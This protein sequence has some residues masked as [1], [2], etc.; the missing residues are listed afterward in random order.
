MIVMKRTKI[1]LSLVSITTAYAILQSIKS[2]VQV[3]NIKLSPIGVGTWAWGNRFLWQYTE[4]DDENLKDTY[5]YVVQKGVNWFDT[6]DSY[7]T[8]SLNGR[9]E[10]L[11][12]KF[13]QGSKFQVSFAT[14]L[15]PY[16]WRIGTASMKSACS[17]SI[18]RLRRPVDVLQLHWPP[19]LGWQEENY[20][21]AFSNLVESGDAKQIGVSNYG[22]IGLRRVDK[23]LKQS[24]KRVF[25]NQVCVHINVC[26]LK[27]HHL[28]L[29]TIMELILPGSIFSSQ[30][31]SADF[32]LD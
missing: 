11:L 17:Q 19:S 26:I 3:G 6:A 13:S 16:P 14:K 5:N 32:W 23:I 30:P 12:G 8:G 9:S 10:E 24:N 25:S 15:A 18:Q 2:P 1:I 27:K 22:P 31:L 21:S 4:K 20:L 7:G 29:C 28:I